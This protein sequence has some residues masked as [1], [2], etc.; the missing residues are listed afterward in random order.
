MKKSL[1][2]ATILTTFFIFTSGNGLSRQTETK[3]DQPKPDRWRGLFLND[4]T[5]DD[6]ISKLGKP[7]TDKIDSIRIYEIGKWFTEEQKKKLFRKLT[8]KDVEGI[9]KAELSFKDNK[10][11]LIELH[12]E[13]KLSPHALSNSYGIE[14]KPHFGGLFSGQEARSKSGLN[15]PINYPP[16]YSL[17]GKAEKSIICAT[18]GN[19]IG[20]AL[21]D[22]AGVADGEGN[23]PGKVIM[24]QIISRS[25]ENRDGADA[26]K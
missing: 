25:L 22:V 24:M 18:V 19:G 4:A 13:K 23:F 2:L 26:L 16:S 11:V 7:E 6:A 21:K 20:S 17:V 15:Q 12:F 9:K 5:P 10:L 1:L 8:Y 3:T 14:F